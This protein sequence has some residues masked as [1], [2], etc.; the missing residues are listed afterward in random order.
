MSIVPPVKS[1]NYKDKSNYGVISPL[2]LQC[3]P[4]VVV[5][6]NSKLKSSFMGAHYLI[7]IIIIKSK[8]KQKEKREDDK[9]F[10]LSFR[11]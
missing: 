3:T 4:V 7:H 9:C 2:Q 11:S 10:G 8:K 1:I 6:K 5:Q